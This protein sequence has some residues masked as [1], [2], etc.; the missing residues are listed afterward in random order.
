MVWNDPRL[1]GADIPYKEFFN[2]AQTAFTGVTTPW[3]T[4]PR[5]LSPEYY[6]WNPQYYN[7][8]Q[9]FDVPTTFNVPP[10]FNIH[11]MFNVLP[12]ANIPQFR[13]PAFNPFI[14]QPMA[15]L[16]LYNLYRPYI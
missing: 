11:P 7:V 1:Y 12:M 2:P 9:Q 5:F 16:P 3:Q 6:G 8:P 14:P 4:M 15:N 10:T 13:P